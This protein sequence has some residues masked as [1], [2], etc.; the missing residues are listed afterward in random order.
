LT[1]SRQ[2]FNMFNPRKTRFRFSVKHH[3]GAIRPMNNAPQIPAERRPGASLPDLLTML[4]L[5]V[6]LIEAAGLVLGHALHGNDFKHL[7]LGGWLLAEGRDPYDAQLM[8]RAAAM[9]KLSGINPFVYLPST[10]LFLW[11]LT[12][13]DY[14]D[15]QSLWFWLNWALAWGVVIA[16][17]AWL[18]VER[19]ALA[20]LAGG[21]FLTCAHPFMRQMTAGQ[22]NVVTAALILWGAGALARRREAQ[23]GLAGALG[24]GWK[25]APALLVAALAGLRRWRALAW[26]IAGSGV[27]LAISW[28]CYGAPVHLRALDVIRQMGYG[29]S[30]WSAFGQEFYRDPFTQSF[31]ALFHHLFTANPHTRPWLDLGPAAADR[32]TLAAS[33]VMIG[34]WLAAALGRATRRRLTAGDPPTATRLYLAASLAMLLVPSLMWDHYAVQTLPAL[35][36]LFGDAR[37][38]RRPGRALGALAI[39]ALLTIPWAPMGPLVQTGAGILLMPLRLWPTLALYAW[40]CRDREEQ[41]AARL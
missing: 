40:L 29:Q 3:R 26:G 8:L 5:G 9:H 24:F 27:L 6:S 23:A 34:L 20:R 25:I 1:K 12:L 21:V 16:G 33:L 30:T 14:G 7:W 13:M 28:I 38:A 36:W 22:M 39:L 4:L 17:P 35:I 31:N 10:G 15:A 32:L 2:K 18:R 19:P 11:P 41:S 37:T